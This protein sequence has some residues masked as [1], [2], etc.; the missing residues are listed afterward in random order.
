MTWLM[1]VFFFVVGCCV[2]SF[3][4]VCIYRLP[5][6]RGV[7]WPGSR[8]PNCLSAIRAY[9]NLPVLSWFVLGGCCRDCG[10]PFS[11][12]YAMLELLTGL[13]FALF[14]WGI[15]V[16]HV[17]NLQVTDPS[18]LLFYLFA[19]VLVC[20][21]VVATFIDFDYKIIPDAVTVPAMVAA[22]AASTVWPWLQTRPITWP[23]PEW[24]GSHPHWQGL[25]T[26]LWGMIV[27]GGMIWLVRIFGRLVFRKEAMGFGD[28]VLMGCVG[29]FLGWQ[30]SLLIF[31]LAPFLGIGAGLVMW[32]RHRQHVLPYG[33]YLSLAAIVMLFGIDLLWPIVHRHMTAVEKLSLALADMVRGWL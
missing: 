25:A 8:C 17:R 26:S 11:I 6:M 15:C 24:L 13:L 33:P 31:L 20:V 12:R 4:N 2:G 9:D 27:G 18:Y 23:A 29:A 7:A 28:V 3:L 16:A 14:Y 21:L 32:L 5:A 30:A 10:Q 22:L 19:M 1:L